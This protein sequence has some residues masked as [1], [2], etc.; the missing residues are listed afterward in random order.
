MLEDCAVGHRSS[1]SEYS[2]Y[3]LDQMISV[4]AASTLIAYAVYTL[5]PATTEKFGTDLL[6]LTV[7][8]PLYGILR[9][10][11]LV[12][13]REGGGNPSELLFRD[14][15]LLLCTVLWALSLVIIIYRPS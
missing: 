6:G 15:P 14:L 5:S 4:V 10:L 9:Y 12:H 2:P 8:F 1:L 11:Y 7:C 13:Q 3:L